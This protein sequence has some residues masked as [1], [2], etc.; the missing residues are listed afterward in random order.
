MQRKAN[1]AHACATLSQD[2][3]RG[4]RTSKLIVQMQYWKQLLYEVAADV[5]SV[6]FRRIGVLARPSR[7]IGLVASELAS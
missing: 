2:P 4:L 7:R 3:A 5:V 6:C 1:S